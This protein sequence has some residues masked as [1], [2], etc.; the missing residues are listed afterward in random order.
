MKKM[1]SFLI[2][3]TLSITGFQLGETNVMADGWMSYVQ[4]GSLNAWMSGVRSK[5]DYVDY[6]ILVE[7]YADFYKIHVPAKGILT[8]KTNGTDPEDGYNSFPTIAIYNGKTEN[9][10]ERWYYY[11]NYDSAYDIRYDSISV[12]AGTY[13]V[14]IYSGSKEYQLYI[15]YKPTITQTRITSVK[16]YK[17]ALK[18]YW[19]KASKVSGYQLQYSLKKNFKGAKTKTIKKASKTSL[20]IKKLMR[21]KKYYIRIRTYKKVGKKTYQSSWSKRKAEKTK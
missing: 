15:G 11:A 20:T 13:Y 19:E 12:S 10:Y 16:T 3:V 4:N 7:S 5:G 17:K 9:I 18:V 6:D 1:I 21:K 8:V 14:E 2:I